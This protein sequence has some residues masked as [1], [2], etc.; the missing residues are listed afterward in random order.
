PSAPRVVDNGRQQTRSAGGNVARAATEQNVLS[1]NQINLIGVYGRP[2]ARRALVRLS[3]GR[4]VKVEV[5]DQLD[6]GRVTAIGESE[7]S[8]QRSGRN[9][10]L[11]LPRA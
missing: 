3:N 10:V 1:L 8:Y 5:G 4:Y 6:R 2:S 7:L 9:V 11:R